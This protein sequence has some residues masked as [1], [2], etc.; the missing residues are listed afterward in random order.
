MS[1]AQQKNVFGEP[2]ASCSDQPKTGFT[3]SGCC[4]T[5]PEDVGVHTVCARMT[6]AFLEF[7]RERGN[8]LSAPVAEF[9]FPGLKA[10]DHWCI[11]AA[12]WKEALDAG[13]AP[14]VSL[15]ATHEKTLDVVSIDELKR[16]AIDLN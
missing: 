14:K 10:G 15:R 8:D 9:D 11:C 4:E 2:I 13:C 16:H 12:R 7:S 3:R 6:Q 5:G 1:D